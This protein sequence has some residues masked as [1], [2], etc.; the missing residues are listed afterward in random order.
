MQNPK[1][2]SLLVACSV[3]FPGDDGLIAEQ[4]RNIFDPL[5]TIIREILADGVAKVEFVAGIGPVTLA[6]SIVGVYAGNVVAWQRSGFD[7]VVGRALVVEMRTM[8][9]ARIRPIDRLAKVIGRTAV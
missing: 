7:P 5:E 6:R 2:F 4:V 8:I 3:R 9:L 1:A